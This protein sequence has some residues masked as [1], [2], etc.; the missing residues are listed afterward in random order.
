MSSLLLGLTSSFMTDGVCAICI[1]F[2]DSSWLA[3]LFT[4]GIHAGIEIGLCEC[5]SL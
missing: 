3:V 5:L 1:L 2:D 4:S